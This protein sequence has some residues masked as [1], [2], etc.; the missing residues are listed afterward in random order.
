MIDLAV[1]PAAAFGRLEPVLGAELALG[2]FGRD[3]AQEISLPAEQPEPVPDLP[4][5]A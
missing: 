2:A 4:F 5:D 3:L 1:R